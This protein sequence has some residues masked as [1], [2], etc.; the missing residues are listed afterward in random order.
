M[1]GL[2]NVS[3]LL[4]ASLV[5]F[6]FASQP[7]DAARPACTAAAPWASLA[8][9]VANVRVWYDQASAADLAEAQAIVA[10]FDGD[11]WPTLVTDL[12][13]QAPLGDLPLTCDGGDDRLDVFVVAGLARLGRTTPESASPNQSIAY[14]E[15]ASGLTGAELQYAV[16]H[17]FM[18]A[19]QWSYLM[20][21][22]QLSYGWMRNALANW[23][24]EAVF[25]GNPTLQDDASCHMNSTFRSIDV[26]SAG[27]CA[28][29]ATRTRD[30]GAYLLFQYIGRTAG[31]AKVREIL[32]ATT[33]S[34][35]G[36]DAIDTNVTGGL[37]TL[38]PKYAKTLW[39][40]LPVTRGNR[41]AFRNWDG[42][43]TVPAYAPDRPTPVDGNLAG[44]REASTT[45]S[46]SVANV[47]ARFYRFTFTDPGTRS[48]MFHNTFYPLFKAG[49]KVSVL[50][51]WR[52][53]GGTWV[54]ENWTSKEWIGLCRDAKSQRV[55]EIVI[56]VASGEVGTTTQ[57]VAATAPTLKRNNIGCWGFS[58]TAKRTDVLGSWSSGSIVA[59]STLL[60]DY[61]P[62][63]MASLQ[64]NDA[65][66]GRL[67]VPI[68]APLFRSSAWSLAEAYTESGCSYS[69]NA[70]ATDLSVFLGGMAAGNLVIN[71]FAESLP[72]TL[73]ND[74]YAVV[75]AK[76]GAYLIQSNSNRFGLPGSVSGPQ[77]DCGTQY[78]SAPALF[79]LSHASAPQAKVVALNGNLKGTFASSSSPDSV[80]F[81]WDLAPLREP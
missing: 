22:P 35:T 44:T 76:R 36:L 32:A 24:V 78:Q 43:R 25:P 53:E 64:Y 26:V 7:A 29:D 6:L 13:F 60:Y 5:A 80:V 30:Y 54:E 79:V 66:T 9:N 81:E 48:L 10:A 63:G 56:V 3:K 67:R 58:G 23:A 69:L 31:N 12:G 77:P 62:N 65:A 21:S 17:Y 71:N 55:S 51:M 70:N 8:G 59:S 46:K 49:K 50:A 18:H 27:P 41:P 15:I 68:S 28:S 52:T 42:L 34:L 75:G 11:I 39:N 74:Q 20:A 57:V 45:L 19:V 16:A 33:V 4:L 2:M 38:W 37:R 40:K 61:R 73:R 14:L 1:G 72:T 47:S